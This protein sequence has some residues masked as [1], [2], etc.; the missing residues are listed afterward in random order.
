MKFLK[1][2]LE[3]NKL[4]KA[5]NGHY[6]ML[7]ELISKS[8]HEDIGNDLFILSYI[9][10]K[11]IIDRMEEYKWNMNGPIVVPMM[12]GDRKTIAFAFQQTIGKLIELGE[13]EGY[14][15]EVQEILDK[16][17]LYFEL[18]KSIPEFM[19]KIM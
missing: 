12:P 3:Y 13:S 7:Q 8:Q 6:Q 16:G 14:S 19:K 17:N 15:E 1:K 4:A 18:D 2:G 10:R 9:G 11:E 5:F